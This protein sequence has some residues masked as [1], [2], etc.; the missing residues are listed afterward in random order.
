MWCDM[1]ARRSSSNI[2]LTHLGLSGNLS[3]NFLFYQCCCL[4]SQNCANGANWTWKMVSQ[5]YTDISCLYILVCILVCIVR[6]SQ[7]VKLCRCMHEGYTA[8]IEDY[9]D[10]AQAMQ[11]LL[12]GMYVSLQVWPLHSWLYIMIVTLAFL[13]FVRACINACIYSLICSIVD[14][15]VSHENLCLGSGMYSLE[16]LHVWGPVDETWWRNCPSCCL[17]LPPAS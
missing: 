13:L 6:D 17:S 12:Q 2:C 10:P 4:S 9:G 5:Y 3:A 14:S 16:W 11:H 8:A 15:F 1:S 7:N